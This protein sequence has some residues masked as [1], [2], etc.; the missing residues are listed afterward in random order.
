MPVPLA[1]AHSTR[2]ISAAETVQQDDLPDPPPY[3]DP[4][5]FPPYQRS[6]IA[7]MEVQVMRSGRLDRGWRRKCRTQAVVDGEE[8]AAPQGTMPCAGPCERI[9]RAGG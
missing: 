2:P 9:G 1:Q 3:M 6:W 4:E 7:G 5:S 8:V